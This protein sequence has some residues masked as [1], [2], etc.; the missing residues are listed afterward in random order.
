MTY[1]TPNYVLSEEH[2]YWV[3]RSGTM[4]GIHWTPNSVATLPKGTFARPIELCYVPK[5]VRDENSQGFDPA[6]DVFCYTN[7]GIIKIPRNIL[8]EV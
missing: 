4:S 8:V 6:T 3:S 1:R 7:R 2:T 5:H